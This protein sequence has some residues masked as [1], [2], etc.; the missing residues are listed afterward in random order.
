ML[1]RTRRIG[2]RKKVSQ[3]FG[4]EEFVLRTVGD[5]QEIVGTVLLANAAV[6]FQRGIVLMPGKEVIR[7]GPQRTFKIA[8]SGDDQAEIA[9]RPCSFNRGWGE[10]SSP[11]S[12]RRLSHGIE[13]ETGSK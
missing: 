12:K 2:R 9:W 10:H 7:L 5:D 11:K 13:R 8:L 6:V 1:H 3:H 4:A